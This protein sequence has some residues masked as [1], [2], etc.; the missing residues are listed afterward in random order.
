MGTQIK[1]AM[2]GIWFKSIA[3]KIEIRIDPYQI[4]MGSRPKYIRLCVLIYL[5]II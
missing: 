3:L 1:L 2:F 5:V 4:E